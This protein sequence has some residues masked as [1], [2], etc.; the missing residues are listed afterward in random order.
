MNSG[1][2]EHVLATLDV[3]LNAFA[4]CEIG[5]DW[6]L[7][8]PPLETVI[9]H[10]VLAGRGHLEFDGRRVPIAAGTIVI[11]PPGISKSISGPDRVRREVSASDSCETLANG[12][13]VFRARW[14]DAA[15]ILGCATLSVSCGESLEL[16]KRMGKP[17]V[18]SLAGNAHFASGFDALVDELTQPGVGTMVVAEC[19]LKQA[20]V[21]ALRTQDHDSGPGFLD[22]LG[23][24][25]AAR[26]ATAMIEAPEQ[27][28]RIATLAELCGMSRSSFISH[29]VR[30]YSKPPGEFLQTVRMHSAARLLV[31]TELPVKCIAAQVGYASRS[32]FSRAFKQAYR[33]DPSAYRA[34]HLRLAQTPTGELGLDGKVFITDALAT[35]PARCADPHRE[36]IALRELAERMAS[37]PVDLLPHFVELAMK[38]TDSAS[39]GLSI[40][41]LNAEPDV[42]KWRFLHGQLAAFE[43]AATPR[44]DSP[45]GVTLDVNHPML[46]SHPERIYEWI[47]A[48]NLVVPEVL[49]VPLYVEG[50]PLGTLW[51]VAPDEG[52][53]TRDDA[54]LLSG[55]A[56]FV[57]IAL[58]MLRT[59]GELGKAL[60]A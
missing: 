11:V 2:L 4:V 60:A 5:A 28:H 10:F 47:A 1:T 45:C 38:L 21:L 9:F 46:L 40:F 22:H 7:R 34:R 36:K 3:K 23:D 12:L 43:G 15:L 42:F 48:E 20:L 39:A 29:F 26:A 14:G 32:Q 49:L 41:D 57:G 50:E 18:A 53:F 16:F 27:P 54:N 37:D 59:G 8:V 17:L 33:T 6:R 58:K 52:H 24:D 31:T 35:R 19:L 51:V 55:L 13:H 56:G 25:R 30:G 44:N